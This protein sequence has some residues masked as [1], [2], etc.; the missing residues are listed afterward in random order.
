MWWSIAALAHPVGDRA[1]THASALRVFRDRVELDYFADVPAALVSPD[2]AV[3]LASGLLVVAD[4]EVVPLTLTEPATVT[5]A[6]HT[7]GFG[8]HLT[9]AV[10]RAP[11]EVSAQ[12]ANLPEAA[13]YFAGDVRVGDGLQ[14]SACSLL[15]TDDDGRFVRDDTNRWLRGEER[16]SLTVR[17]VAPPVAWGWVVPPPPSPVKARDAWVPP[18]RTAD[19]PLALAVL[20]AVGA[21]CGWASGGPWALLAAIGA[22]AG[23]LPYASAGLAGAAA[24]A[25]AARRTLPW[26]AAAGL[27]AAA[28][29]ASAEHVRVRLLVAAA[30]AGGAAL[31]RSGRGVPSPRVRWLILAAALV[32]A[33][34][35]TRS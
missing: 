9:G 26:A 30:V 22:A 31:A 25:A 1:A 23:G 24:V 28:V 5:P 35:R 34:L 33:I 2:T 17:L 14:V 10:P 15:P 7:V 13:N 4:G 27:G 19:T 32:T 20:A 29:V 8:L 18:P 21:A 6:E 16:R 3:E 12:T 11:A